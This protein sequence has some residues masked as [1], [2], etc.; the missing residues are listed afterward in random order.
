M[1][2]P[3]PINLPPNGFATH[4]GGIFFFPSCSRAMGGAE[5]LA[6]LKLLVKLVVVFDDRSMSLIRFEFLL[7]FSIITF[8]YPLRTDL[9]EDV[10][11]VVIFVVDDVVVAGSDSFTSITVTK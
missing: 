8:S 5:G 9:K 3:T 6:L 1:N 10:D 11:D 7:L 4:R 2:D